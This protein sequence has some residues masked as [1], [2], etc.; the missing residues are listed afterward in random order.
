MLTE[1]VAM[2][3]RIAKTVL[4]AGGAT[5]LPS[6]FFLHATRHIFSRAKISPHRQLREAVNNIALV[7]AVERPFR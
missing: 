2:R 4:Y 7:S 3:Q 6:S 5:S 1:S